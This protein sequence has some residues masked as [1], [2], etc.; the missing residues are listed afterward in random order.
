MLLLT[1]GLMLRPMLKLSSNNGVLCWMKLML[2]KP[3]QRYMILSKVV[4]LMKTVEILVLK[5]I[6]LKVSRSF[7]TVILKIL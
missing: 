3:M 5:W 2:M 6:V 7:A 4:G 1:I